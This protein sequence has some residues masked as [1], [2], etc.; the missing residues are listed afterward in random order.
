MGP[1]VIDTSAWLEFLIGSGSVADRLVAEA[2]TEGTEIVVPEVVRME[3][4]IGDPAEG[5]AARR[6]S[7]LDSFSLVPHEPMLDSEVAAGLHRA[8]RRGGE[9]VRSL[10][11]CL[12]AAAA[13]RLDLPVL[14]R[15]RDFEVLARHSDLLTI[16]TL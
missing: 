14:H 6:R 13:L 8:C 2:I 15:D 12:V 10:I 9:T 16:S 5:W 1:M 7:F 4:L 11:D 3:L